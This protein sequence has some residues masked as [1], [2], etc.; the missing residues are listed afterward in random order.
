MKGLLAFGFVGPAKRGEVKTTRAQANQDCQPDRLI[1]FSPGE[2]EKFE[3]MSFLI[4]GREQ[5]SAPI[6]GIFFGP[7]A[8]I[9]PVAYD[10]MKAGDDAILRMCC[11]DDMPDKGHTPALLVT[12]L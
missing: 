8:S 9:H 11:I 1:L 5:L 3:V 2:A 7:K 10:K 12:P 6:P 4:A